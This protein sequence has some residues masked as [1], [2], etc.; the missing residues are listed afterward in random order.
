MSQPVFIPGYQTEIEISG[1]DLTLVGSVV[2][3]S[4]DQNAV[5]KPTFGTR[6]RRTI[7][8]QGVY[9]IDVNGHL[10]ASDAATLWAIRATEGPVAWQVTIGSDTAAPATEAG[11]I[12]G[13]A[14]V[15]NM[16]WEADAE[17]NWAWSMTLEGDGVPIYA[18]PPAP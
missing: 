4:D 15:T 1:N 2:S 13:S 17:G 12:N 9:T 11:I 8:G 14:I 5:P 6:Y 18:P 7:A 16:T 3:Y 10:S